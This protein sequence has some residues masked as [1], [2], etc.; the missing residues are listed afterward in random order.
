MKTVLKILYLEKKYVESEVTPIIT[1]WKTEWFKPMIG[2]WDIFLTC[3]R[4][5]SLK[6]PC[7]DSKIKK[8]LRNK[9]SKSLVLTKKLSY[10]DDWWRTTTL[11]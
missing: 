10:L 9:T 5:E 3:A 11:S 7:W 6:H 1:L 8:L 2:E 4:C